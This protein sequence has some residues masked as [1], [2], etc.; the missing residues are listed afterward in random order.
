MLDSGRDLEAAPAVA[1]ATLGCKVNQY[2]SA[3][4]ET[5]LQKAGFRIVPFAPGADAY[6]IN[7]CSV[8]DRADSESRRTA[9]R[10][11]RFGPSARVVMTGCFAQTDAP[12]AAIP[13]V[14]HVVGMNRVDDLIA[15]VRGDLDP[16]R[17]RI[18]ID[19][20]RKAREVGPLGAESF[21][22]Q[23]RAFLKV[24]EGC[25]LFCTFCIVPFA[26][27]RS[28]SVPPRQIL[29]QLEHLA[30]LGYREVVLTGVHLGTYGEDLEP[31][32]GLV[33]LLEMI[34]ENPPAARLRLSS[35]DPPEI[36]PRL[37]RLVAQSGAFCPHFHVPLQA[38]DDVVLARMRRRYSAGL[39][40]EVLESIRTELPDAGIGTDVIAGF[41]G[42]TEE[43]FAQTEQF[44][45]DMPFTY[46][47]V[48]PYSPRRG[49]TAAKRNDH[50]PSQ[51]I[52]A[53]AQRLRDLDAEKR[54]S[55]AAAMVGRRLE[56]LVED[57]ADANGGRAGYAPNYARI[58]LPP[59]APPANAIAAV[60]V[61][62]VEDGARLIGRVADR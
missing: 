18:L 41:P 14:D 13:E 47:H 21:C 43:E 5:R 30:G 20:L 22:G 28:R 9:R 61:I 60:D 58:H 27:G 35:V 25:D 11:R 51:V 26:R 50:L 8:T 48:F 54:A 31:R 39:A 23:T 34:A 2:D 38:G 46:L 59:P 57:D 40:R 32:L 15:A 33:D 19:D 55:F 36:T 56:V 6:V 17:G 7:S 62:A 44:V 45:R 1:I 37:L 53:R 16:S 29:S 10:A 24:Q 42:E 49:T 12:G 3:A 4:L 52:T